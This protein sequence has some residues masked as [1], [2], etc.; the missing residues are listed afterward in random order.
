MRVQNIFCYHASDEWCKN[1][2]FG[3]KHKIGMMAVSTS[4][5]KFVSEYAKI[6]I[7]R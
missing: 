2:L 3:S 5:R 1:E 6:D 7:A 4:M